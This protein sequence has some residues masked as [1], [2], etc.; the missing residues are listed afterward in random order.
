MAI[1]TMASRDASVTSSSSVCSGRRAVLA[2]SS[3]C[4]GVLCHPLHLASKSRLGIAL[5]LRPGRAGEDHAVH[6]QRANPH[7]EVDVRQGAGLEGH[8]A[9]LVVVG[10]AAT[11]V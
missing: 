8:T 2:S 5:F 6:R 1:V 11:C 7:P 3:S 9:L 10:E 4:V